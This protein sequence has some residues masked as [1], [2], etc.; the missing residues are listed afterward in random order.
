[1]HQNAIEKTL[2]AG[3]IPAP[4]FTWVELPA[5]NAVDVTGDNRRSHHFCIA[6]LALSIID[7]MQSF[8]QIVTQA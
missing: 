5:R 6:Q 4:G 2:F 7:A 3:D 8:Q 1:M